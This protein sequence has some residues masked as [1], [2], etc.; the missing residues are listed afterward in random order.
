[1]RIAPFVALALCGA[2]CGCWMSSNDFYAGAQALTPFKPGAVKS[3][4]AKG[5]VTHFTLALD[6]GGYTLIG[7][8]KDAGANGFGMHFYALAGSRNLVF[9][10]VSL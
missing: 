7:A 10:I 3:T 4:N 6:K 1:M 2:L 8:D 5:E 9:D